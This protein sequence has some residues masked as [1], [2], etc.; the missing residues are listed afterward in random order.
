MNEQTQTSASISAGEVRILAGRDVATVV[1]RFDAPAARQ[2]EAV[3]R[4]TDHVAREWKGN[5]EFVA[6]VLLRGRERGGITCYSQWR[7]PVDG[8]APG[9]VPGSWSLEAILPA[10]T[11]LDSRTYAV[12]FSDS[13]DPPTRVSL[14]GTPFVHFGIFGVVPENQD[15]LLELAR[16][17][18]PRSLEVTPGLIS[19]NFHRSVD[20]SQVIN[21][22]TWSTFD[23]MNQLLQQPGFRDDSLY[24]SGVAEFQ[25]D[26]FD[27][28]AVEVRE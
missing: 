21:L 26:F 12:E 7:P 20:G 10:F 6:A 25:P 5:P 27:V 17:N 19:I 18:A 13:A 2:P 8:S 1:E 28:V 22:G 14:D 11:M 9:A 23:H 15:R 4:A 16:E 3:E 24:W